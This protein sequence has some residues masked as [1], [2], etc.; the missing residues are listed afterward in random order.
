MMQL[1]FLIF[2][3]GLIGEAGDQLE[4]FYRAVNF[5]FFRHVCLNAPETGRQSH[6]HVNR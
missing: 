4:A 5:E 1:V 2:E 6:Q 3:V